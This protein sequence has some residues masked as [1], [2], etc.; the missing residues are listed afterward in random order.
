MEGLRKYA[1]E[2]WQW[3]VA[4]PPDYAFLL[5]LPFLVALTGLLAELAQRRR[6]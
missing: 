3:L 4:L 2:L 1:N 6:Q 5:S